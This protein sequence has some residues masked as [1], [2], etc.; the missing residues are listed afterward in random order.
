DRVGRFLTA[1][2]GLQA[3]SA[4][5]GAGASASVRE[6]GG[7]PLEQLGAGLMAGIAPGMASTAAAGLTRGL[8]R[9]NKGAQ[10]R[11]TIDDF[12]SVGANPSVGQASGNRLIQG[13]ENVLGGAPTSAGVIGRFV[14]RQADDIGAGLAKKS[15]GL[16]RNASAERAGRAVERG[17]AAFAKGIK[18]KRA[19]LYEAA[20]AAIPPT[21]ETPLTNTRQALAE[22]TA[23]TPG[24]E[25]TSAALVNPKI[26][27]IASNVGEDFMAAQAQGRAGI[28]DP[29]LKDIRSRIG[30]ELSD[31]ALSPDKP[32]AQSKRL[33][34][35]MSRDMEEVAQRQG[36][37]AVRVAKRANS[38]MRASADRLET[39]ERVV[40]KAGGPEKVY[41]AVMSGTR[42]GGTTLRSVMQSLDKE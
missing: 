31:F 19:A 11:R 12:A 4:G 21:V 6:A 10:M 36:P 17:V 9:G 7:G 26:A 3:V 37:E 13:A 38:F 34:A 25:S 5:T 42:D 33:Y 27:G 24:A 15:D 40:D 18:A 14:E 23:L 41:N 30:E 32:T 28:R 29:A 20:D 22:L 1:Q 8:V 2:P 16:F 35:A 39:I